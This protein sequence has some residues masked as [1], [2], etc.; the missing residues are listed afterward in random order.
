MDPTVW[1]ISK[2]KGEE[3]PWRRKFLG[4]LE[5]KASFPNVT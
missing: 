1:Q 2:S 4:L 3:V 5:N